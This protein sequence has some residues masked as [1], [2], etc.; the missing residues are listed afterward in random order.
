M[1]P[2]LVLLFGVLLSGQ[3][4]AADNI[5][6]SAYP[7][8]AQA[9]AR[10][11][12]KTITLRIHAGEAR[13]DQ[14]LRVP[15][16]IGLDFAPGAKLVIAD[17]VSLALQ[18]P[19]V[20][21][22]GQQL[23]ALQGK[24]S[25]ISEINAPTLYPQWWGARGD[26]K[27][28]DTTAFQQASAVINA[29]GRGHLKIPKGIYIVGRQQLKSEAQAAGP[30]YQYEEIISIRK[31]AGPVLIEGEG[32][33]ATT[34][35]AAA[36]LHFGSFDPHSGAAYSPPRLPFTDKNYAAATY[37]GMISAVDNRQVE[38]PGLELDGNAASLEL[39]GQ[40]GDHGRQLGGSGLYLM[41]N[42]KAEVE[43]Q[44]THHHALD[45]IMI[46]Y[47]QLT[48]ASLIERPG[49]PADLKPH[50]LDRVVS[51]YNG[52]QGLSWIG[53]NSLRVTN[54][55]FN[56]T[57]QGK[58]GLSS[59]PG[60][61]LDIEAE[62]SIA[63]NGYFENCEFLDNNGVGVATDSG[64]SSH[65][66]FKN[67]TVRGSKNWAL[68]LRRPHMVFEDSRIIGRIAPSFT[69]VEGPLTESSFI[70]PP[71]NPP[72]SIAPAEVLARLNAKGWLAKRPGGY[73][74][75]REVNAALDAEGNNIHDALKELFPGPLNSRNKP[76]YG[77]YRRVLIVLQK[78]E[79]SSAPQ[80]INTRFE[81]IPEGAPYY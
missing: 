46:G 48:V 15:P 6:L 47:R 53:G 65:V 66:R 51:E 11:G 33:S 73:E 72:L 77:D 2:G 17:K 79:K 80:F 52:R 13:V 78:H 4:A 54:S 60:A 55:K 49:K 50:R 59:P 14:D 8:L 81:K 7:S 57:G 44:H 21:A 12:G 9:V 67:V 37:F 63:Y 26:G 39:G 18:G 43:D 69:A 76:S 27:S 70:L 75:T 19:L 3:V 71:P 45:G 41:N 62:E 24:D 35:R 36:G 64:D 29:M 74:L 38:I 32:S 1:V 5:S 10:N 20:A 22:P 30:Y 68:W 34:L 42:E 58:E 23:F 61:G 16:N 28:N 40:W 31:T 56:H 25:R